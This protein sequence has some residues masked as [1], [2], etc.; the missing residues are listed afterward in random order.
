M[1]EYKIAK[2]ID[3][4]TIVIN[5]GENKGIKENQK[6]QIIGK[7]G[8]EVKDPD[9]G[10]SLGRLDELKGYVF[11]TT[12]YPNMTIATSPARS[13]MGLTNSIAGLTT[14]MTF[15]NPLLTSYHETLNVDPS[16]ITGGFSPKGASPI[17]V[18]DIVIP[19]N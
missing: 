19:I 14:G 1:P 3:D 8:K 16:Q 5:A 9:T 11:A 2:I 10:E 13:A 6:F 17:V 18:G 4:H 7:K 12:I 15:Q